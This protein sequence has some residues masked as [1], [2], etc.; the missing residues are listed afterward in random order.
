V[1]LFDFVQLFGPFIMIAALI[2]FCRRAD[3]R[4]REPQNQEQ[5]QRRA[6][7]REA[8]RLKFIFWMEEVGINLKCTRCL[9]NDFIMLQYSPH[10]LSFQGQCKACKAK[11]W[12]K[13][14]RTG[15]P[16]DFSA[17]GFPSYGFSNYDFSNLDNTIPKP[18]RPAEKT[19]RSRHISKNVENE[20]WRRD[21]GR[22]CE[23]GSKEN[24]ELDHIIPFSKG[25]SNT[26]RNLQ[27]L[28]K[29]CNAKKRD[30]I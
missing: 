2:V 15:K 18:V 23:C 29:T 28:C 26:A 5:E 13:A 1:D 24:I 3:K 30:R 6:F 22:C 16:F 10:G 11:K 21:Q 27:L 20:V 9:S 19:K 14:K 8:A 7:E 25:G 4:D 12:F 17:C